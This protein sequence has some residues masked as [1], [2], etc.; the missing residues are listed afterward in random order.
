MFNN[1]EVAYYRGEVVTV[2]RAYHVGDELYLHIRYDDGSEEY[3]TGIETRTVVRFGEQ[4]VDSEVVSE[5]EVGNEPQ[6]ELK[7][8]V[9]EDT[10]VEVTEPVA[11]AIDKKGEETPIYNLQKFVE[12]HN[13]VLESVQMCLDGTQK[14]HKGFSF[15]L[16]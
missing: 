3:L 9:S 8:E 5:V 13:M 2:I 7:N 15:R 1:N 16:P 14:T 4:N 12:E 10:P 6:E 11:Y